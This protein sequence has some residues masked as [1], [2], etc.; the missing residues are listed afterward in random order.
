MVPL[1]VLRTSSLC[2]MA[3]F[4]GAGRRMQC[5]GE[6]QEDEMRRTNAVEERLAQESRLQWMRDQARTPEDA[7]QWREWAKRDA[8]YAEYEA[9]EEAK[10]R[11]GPGE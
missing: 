3:P 5:A 11:G 10:R 8:A 4:V 2:P 7:E 1:P 9:Y 6:G